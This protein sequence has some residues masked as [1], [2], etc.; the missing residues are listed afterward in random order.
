MISDAVDFELNDRKRSS[1]REPDSSRR[2]SSH[3]KERYPSTADSDGEDFNMND[4]NRYSRR[5]LDSSRRETSHR[6]ERFPSTADSIINDLYNEITEDSSNPHNKKIP[7]TSRLK[8]NPMRINEE[9]MQPHNKTKKRSTKLHDSDMGYATTRA[10]EKERSKKSVRIKEPTMEA[11]TNTKNRS[12]KVLGKD[13]ESQIKELKNDIKNKSHQLDI[14]TSTTKE[15]RQNGIHF[16]SHRRA[17]MTIIF[18][19]YAIVITCLVGWLAQQYFRIP[20]KSIT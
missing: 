12:T 19:A 15:T 1:R 16:C 3:R 7:T 8:E 6:T 2:Q 9:T 13:L 4:E 11:K 18:L 10:N 20:G 14:Q 5:K 17:K